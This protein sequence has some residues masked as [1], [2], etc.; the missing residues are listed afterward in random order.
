MD[1]VSSSDALGSVFEPRSFYKYGFFIQS[2]YARTFTVVGYMHHDKGYPNGL[3]RLACLQKN[4]LKGQ[5]FSRFL[6]FDP[7]DP[8]ESLKG[9]ESPHHELAF[10]RRHAKNFVHSYKD[11]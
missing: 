9:E 3:I 7:I 4:P 5:N 6:K 11:Y 10:L 2:Q 1:T 8:T